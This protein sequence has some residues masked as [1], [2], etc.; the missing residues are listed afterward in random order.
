MLRA[1][2]V[3]LA[4]A[5]LGGATARVA[6]PG[7]LA[8][9][10][11]RLAATLQ[12]EGTA[13]VWV[14]FRGRPDLRAA[15]RVAD[16]DERGERVIE[17]LRRI[18]RRDQ[19][20]VRRLLRE[21]G[22][23]FKA[24]WVVN[25]LVVQGDSSLVA[26]LAVRPEV[27]R[28]RADRRFSITPGSSTRG[29]A[30]ARRPATVEWNVDRVRAPL[31]W[32]TFNKHGE[33]VVIGMYD[34]GVRWTHDAIDDRYRGVAAAPDPANIHDYNWFDALGL[35][36]VPIDESGIGTAETGIA[37]GDDGMGNQVGVAPAAQWI[38]ARACQTSSCTTS[39]LL[40]AGQWLLA[41]TRV[42]GSGAD[43]GHRPHVVVGGWGGAGNNVA[44]QTMVQNWV[45]A[46]IFPVFM[47]GSSGPGNGSVLYPGSYPESYAAGA[48]GPNGLIANF[49]SRG[50]SPIGGSV[51]PDIAAPGVM[52]R[53]AFNTSDTAYS[54]LNSTSLAAAHLGG[55]LALL[56]SVR[57]S[58]LRDIAGTTTVLDSSAVNT[59]SATCGAS[60]ANDNTYG[61]GCLD[62][63]AAANSGPTTVDVISFTARATAGG[64]RLRW[65]TASETGLAGFR[66]YRRT[67][68]GRV[69]VGGVVDASGAAR[70]REYA[71][72]LRSAPA[73]AL[74][75]L[76]VLERSGRGRWIGPAGR[77]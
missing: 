49:S 31:V 9:V 15:T 55:A 14:E 17:A 50:P 1:L 44:F 42:D 45:A 61:E 13:K 77:R 76:R 22:I 6:Q 12:R 53:S 60:A 18:A 10:E 35:S 68:A 51:K 64:I 29:P 7:P 27:T 46:G 33:A 37:V 5:A 23:P 39:A 47:A 66:L 3:V 38:A 41:P 67:R 2:G 69:A 75:W 19:A 26:T 63:F 11:G 4:V 28:L 21:R 71:V 32:S 74:Y 48:I 62:A 24:F 16:W 34:S 36:S 40:A 56:W 25:T 20:A 73:E 30:R 57:P 43:A 65:R 52:I 70:G 58:L 59:P 8:K 54:T 72:T